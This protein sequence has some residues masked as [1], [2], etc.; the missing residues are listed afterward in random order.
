MNFQSAWWYL[1]LKVTFLENAF[2]SGINHQYS[3]LLQSNI[4]VSIFFIKILCPKVI[5]PSKKWQYK[6][7]S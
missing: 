7:Q 3:M 1:P 6:F 2:V 5:A 4:D